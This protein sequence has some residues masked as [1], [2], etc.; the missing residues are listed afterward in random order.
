MISQ[1]FFHLKVALNNIAFCTYVRITEDT[2]VFVVDIV[3]IF[4][5]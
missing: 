3:D 1:M 2:A 5:I 4:S